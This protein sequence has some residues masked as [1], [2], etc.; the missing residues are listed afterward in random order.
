MNT[1][2]STAVQINTESGALSA[3]VLWPTS[4][5]PW[6]RL[7]VGGIILSPLYESREDAIDAAEVV[8]WRIAECEQDLARCRGVIIE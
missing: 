7:M 2:T 1:R 8:L 5:V 4:S 6:F 3:D